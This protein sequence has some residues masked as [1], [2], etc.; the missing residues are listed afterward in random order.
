MARRLLDHD[1]L[2]GITE[3]FV[4]HADGSWSIETEQNVDAIIESVTHRRNAIDGDR[5]GEMAYVGTIPAAMRAA[6]P[7]ALRNN[8]DPKGLEKWLVENS[9]FLVRRF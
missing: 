3:W 5:Y 2:T 4:T 6:M 7:E 9:K 1:P 8:E